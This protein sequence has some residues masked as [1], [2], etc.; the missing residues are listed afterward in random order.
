M[1]NVELN[2][3]FK[4][5]N[6][7]F[8]SSRWLDWLYPPRCRFCRES[9]FDAGDCFCRACRERIRRVVH[10]LCTCCGRP[11]L[12][13]SG[14][15]HLC[16]NCIARRPYF[17]RARAWACYPTEDGEAHPLREA[18]QRFKYGRKV[19]LGKPLGRLMAVECRNFFDARKLDL[20]L[21]VPLHPKRL[22]WRG[23]NQSVVL[24][25]AIGQAW[26]LPVDPFVLAR[27]RETPP[28]TQLNEEE[29]RKNMRRAFAVKAEKSI[30]GQAVLLIDD[31]YTSGATVNECSR[32]LKRGG[33]KEVSVLTLARTI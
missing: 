7:K 27:S 18:V 16:G 10:P 30:A 17:V 31:V 2:L 12:D 13:T 3:K 23:F 20:I 14:D 33:A 22:R 32:A 21:P 29:R 5:H 19:S 9:V 11:F 1:L 26:R 15:D 6:S 25:R 24:A 8:Q 4:I 28:Q